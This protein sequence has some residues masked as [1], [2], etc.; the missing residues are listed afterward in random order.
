MRYEDVGPAEALDLIRTLPP[1]SAFRRAVAGRYGEFSEAEECAARL[2][3]AMWAIACARAGVP[4]EEVPHVLRPS[5]LRAA[6]AERDRAAAAA[7]RIEDTEWE[8]VA[9]G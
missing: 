4:E 1:G 5:E 8:E 3:D 6:D 2:V 7:R 9:N